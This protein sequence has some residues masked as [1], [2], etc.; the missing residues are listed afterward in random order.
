MAKEKKFR[1][2]TGYCQIF[3][4]KIVIAREGVRGELAEAVYGN[5]ISRAL[6]VYS[7]LA[8]VFLFFAFIYYIFGKTINAIVCVLFVLWLIITVLFSLNNSAAPV[9]K[10]NSI[11]KAKFVKGIP[12]ITR[13]RF[14]IYFK[15]EK[16]RKKKRLILLPGSLCNR[17]EAE[18]EALKIMK[19]EK[20]I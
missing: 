18:K 7:V 11:I 20:F 14:V 8:L 2:K 9:I 12:F 16:G 4:D 6:I 13:S 10:R 5:K 19:G 3:P 15:D 17:E 1:T